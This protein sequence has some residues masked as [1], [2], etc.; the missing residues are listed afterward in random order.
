MNRKYTSL[1][2]TEYTVATGNFDKSRKP[3]T[4]IIIH[5]TVSTYKSAISWFGNPKA[6]T[7]AHY[8]ISNKGELA[9]MLEEYYTAYHSGNYGVNQTSIGIEHEWYNGITPS[10]K[11][12]QESALLVH[13]ICHFYGLSI[14]RGVI[15]GHKEI[16]ATS[17]PNQIDVDRIVREAQALDQPSDLEACLVAHKEA[18]K[19]AD[20]K[21]KQ[22]I[23]LQKEKEELSKSLAECKSKCLTEYKRGREDVKK[24]YLEFGEK[25]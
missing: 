16:V 18:V 22:V 6:G 25:L 12:Y 2:Y 15:K 19:S 1:P 17:C 23:A 14:N 13:D 24:A 21:Q 7:S 10:D 9:A 5:S 11:L 20:E 4:Q 3:I 8:I